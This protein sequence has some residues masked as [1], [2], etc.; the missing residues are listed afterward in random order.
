MQIKLGKWNM[1]TV[2][3]EVDFGLYLDGG[4]AGEILMPARYVPQECEVGDA[5]E[6][7]VYL[8]QEERLVATR[9]E[10]KA[11]VGDFAFLKVAWTNRFGAFLD[12]GLMKDLFVPFGEQKM[13]MIQGNSYIVHVH[14]D[15]ETYRI[16][17]SAKVERYLSSDM[18]D[19]E[20]GDEVSVLIWQKTD[21]GF[22]A[23]VDNLYSGLIYNDEIFSSIR[24]GDCLK[25]FV[26]QVRP[27]GKIDIRLQ[28]SGVEAIEDFSTILLNELKASNGFLPFTDHSSAEAISERFQVSKKTFKKA[29]GKLYKQHLIRLEENGI[30]LEES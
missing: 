17:A 24:T 5:V 21:M 26:K 20:T 12:W 13:R 4:E 8:D 23:I 3:K 15:E 25:A 9:E 11:E 10:A 27:D 6:V 7:F 22:K 18:P 28:R 16:V 2:V 30:V 1:L 19:Y 29:V 14:I